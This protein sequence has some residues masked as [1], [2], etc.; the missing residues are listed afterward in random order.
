MVRQVKG[1]YQTK[2]SHMQAYQNFVLDYLQNFVEYFLVVPRK[3]SVVANALATSTSNFDMPSNVKGKYRVE[4]RHRPTVPYNNGHW[5][6]F[7]NDKQ[8]ENFLLMKEE[9]S[10]MKWERDIEWE[11][12]DKESFINQMKEELD[13]QGSELKILQLKDNILPRGL[14]PLDELFDHNDVAKRPKLALVGEGIEECNIAT[15]EHPEMINLSKTLSPD[16]KIRYLELFTE[17]FDVFAWG[18]EDLKVYDKEIIQHIIPVKK[19]QKP[20]K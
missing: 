11:D 7:E 8:V 20:F 3:D 5:K 15:V 1:E 16:I 9:L 4:V 14:V 19:D 13:K 17:F 12:V 6:V 2:H 10:K 18:Y